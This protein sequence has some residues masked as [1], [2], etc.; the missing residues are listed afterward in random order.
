MNEIMMMMMVMVMRSLDAF[1]MK[2]YEVSERE[3]DRKDD[4][5]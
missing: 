5:S 2:I 1:Y 3:T 4:A